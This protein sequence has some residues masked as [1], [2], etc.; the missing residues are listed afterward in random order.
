M[1]QLYRDIIKHLKRNLT[2]AM[3]ACGIQTV[4]IVLL[5]LMLIIA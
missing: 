3:V 2:L 1:E 4:V 5:I